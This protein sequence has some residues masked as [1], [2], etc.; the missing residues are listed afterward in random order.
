MPY[1]AIWQENCTFMYS[2]FNCKMPLT[3]LCFIK[4]SKANSSQK[5]PLYMRISLNGE[6]S[7]ISLKRFIDPHSWDSKRQQIRGRVEDARVVNVYIQSMKTALY[8]HYNACIIRGEELSA[9]SFKDSFL[10]K[11]TRKKTLLETFHY[12]NSKVESQIDKGFSKATFIRYQTC[13]NHIKCFI[14]WKFNTTDIPIDRVNYEFISDLHFYFR[15]IKNSCNNTALKYISNFRTVVN[16]ALKYG[17]IEKDPFVGFKAK[18]DVV[19]REFLTEDEVFAIYNK[20]FLTERLNIVKDIFV[21]SCFTGLAYCDVYK[22]S[23]N[24]ITIGLDGCKWIEIDRTKTN[25]ISKI[26]L[27]PIAESIINKYRDNITCIN[28][29]KL[30]PVYSNQKM[31]SYLKEIAA[32]CE[33]NKELTCH[34]ARHT[35][36]TSITLA[37]NVPLESVQKMLGHK[38]IRITQHYSKVL[39]K[40]LSHDIKPLKE[41][42]AT[43]PKSNLKT[44][45]IQ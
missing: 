11:G 29:N 7:E 15:T 10:N 21:F 36:A 14:K 45:I 44:N 1:L 34:I 43:T 28:E 26:P 2:K 25:S 17:W 40:K 9:S 16:M 19:E 23:Q 22:L 32:I 4:R 27:L 13:L 31:N 20:Q 18:F 8:N 42:Y 37:N 38:S 33:I 6:R 24:H 35:F 30:L 5:V 12:H 41:R 39:D 3:L